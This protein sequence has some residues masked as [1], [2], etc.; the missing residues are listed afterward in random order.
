MK[1]VVNEQ[2]KTQTKMISQVEIEM[3]KVKIMNLGAPVEKAVTSMKD[4]LKKNLKDQK[5]LSK[6]LVDDVSNQTSPVVQ[7]NKCRSPNASPVSRGDRSPARER[8]VLGSYYDPEAKN[9]IWFDI[10]KSQ[11]RYE[12]L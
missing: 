2:I 12:G 9:M 6:E 11:Q 1:D 7:V 8:D 3:E 4:I 10:E 5:R